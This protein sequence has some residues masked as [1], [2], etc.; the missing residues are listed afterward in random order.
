MLRSMDAGRERAFPHDPALRG[1]H[2]VYR[3][4]NLAPTVADVRVPEAGRPVEIAVALLVEKPDAFSSRDHELLASDGGH[5]RERVPEAG[6]GTF[7]DRVH[8]L[9]R[10][11]CTGQV[12][13]CD[14]LP[15]A[16]ARL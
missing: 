3:I 11:L 7:G 5:V 4:G 10:H 15:R 13:G 14:P 8:S 6:V 9:A 1:F 12:V 2:A 16:F